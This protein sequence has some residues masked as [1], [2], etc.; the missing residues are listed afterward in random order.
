[1]KKRIFTNIFIFILFVISAYSLSKIGLLMGDVINFLSKNNWEGAFESIKYLAYMVLLGFIS[2]LIAFRLIFSI[3]RDKMLFLKNKL[4]K[5]DL[6]QGSYNS[7]N[8]ST[9]LETVY[10]GK[11]LTVYNILNL[12]LTMFFA[13][14][15]LVRIDFRALIIAII[16]SSLPLIAPAI[17]K[18][19]IKE[20]TNN[21]IKQTEL[22]Q[23]FTF[24]HLEINDEIKRYNV[25]SKV[26]DKY[27][28]LNYIQE[29]ARLR[30]KN[31]IN[32]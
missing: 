20:H 22:F 19:R 4:I 2:N 5:L 24:E 25:V 12:V 28:E 1:M 9:N 14:L 16:A 15:A 11:F 13:I 3:C 10:S 7:A 18:K 8:Y 26:F 23:K 29:S 30:Q 31:L 27:R 32:F 21:L 6:H 17:T